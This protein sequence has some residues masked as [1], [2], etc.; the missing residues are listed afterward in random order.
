MVGVGFRMARHQLVVAGG[1]ALPP[2]ARLVGPPGF[3]ENAGEL[4]RIINPRRFGERLESATARS[5]WL[6]P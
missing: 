3:A 6:S 4:R 1:G 5:V 2:R